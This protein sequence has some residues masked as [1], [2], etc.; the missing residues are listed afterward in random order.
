M[1]LTKHWLAGVYLFHKMNCN[2]EGNKLTEPVAVNCCYIMANLK[3]N[4]TLM[5]NLLQLKAT[6]IVWINEMIKSILSDYE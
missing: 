2:F 1:S 6:L 3:L 5:A 4:F